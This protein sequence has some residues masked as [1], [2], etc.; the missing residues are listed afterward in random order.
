MRLGWAGKTAIAGALPVVLGLAAFLL[1][2]LD[3]LGDLT[4]RHV[5]DGLVREAT[6]AARAVARGGWTP[7]EMEAWTRELKAGI[8]ARVTIIDGD[9]TFLGDSDVADVASVENHGQRPE[10][11]GALERGTAVRI[12]HSRT[13]DR[14]LLYAAARVPGSRR[15][16]RL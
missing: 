10:V 12:G 8:G 1:V 3:R 16:V 9:G 14:D 11:L 2:T 5:R 6:V 13:V 15:V 4:E 7:G